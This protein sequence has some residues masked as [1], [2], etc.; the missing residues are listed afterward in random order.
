[1]TVLAGVGVSLYEPLHFLVILGLM[2][3]VDLRHPSFQPLLLVEFLGLSGL[4]RR[5]VFV[6]FGLVAFCGVK[7][8]RSEKQDGKEQEMRFGFHGSV[9]SNFRFWFPQ[10]QTDRA[11]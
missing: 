11:E 3:L 8:D 2:G 7:H 10:V 4:H 1:M 5:F 9:L 6:G